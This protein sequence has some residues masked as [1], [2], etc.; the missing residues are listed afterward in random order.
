MPVAQQRSTG[1]G[2]GVGA[3]A[4]STA[5]AKGHLG[6]LL[7]Q[8]PHRAHGLDSARGH[9]RQAIDAFLQFGQDVR[10][11]DHRHPFG[12]Q[13]ARSGEK[14]RMAPGSRPVVGSSRNST[15]GCPAGLGKPRRWRMPW[16][17][18]APG[19]GGVARPDALQQGRA[20]LQ[21]RAFEAG[22]NR[23]VP[24]RRGCR[25]APRSRAG[26]R[27][28]RSRKRATTEGLTDGCPGCGDEAEH[29]L[30]QGALAGAVV[31]YQAKIR[32]GMSRLHAID[33]LQAPWF[34]H[35]AQEMAGALLA[36]KVCHAIDS[37]LEGGRMRGWGST[38][39]ARRTGTAGPP[40]AAPARRAGQQ[41]LDAGVR[42]VRR[43]TMSLAS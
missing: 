28:A 34:A 11:D 40:G 30:E 42:Q 25:T 33:G 17:I 4:D 39:G 35:A 6:A 36:G 1:R 19:G 26:S 7:A 8:R 18:C 37:N 21:R 41:Q 23:S 24:G 38:T 3:P 12:L 16:S 14:S 20:W 27:A 22:E 13:F 15:R 43:S 5:S 29:H 32:P 31:A 2:G 9:D 10:G